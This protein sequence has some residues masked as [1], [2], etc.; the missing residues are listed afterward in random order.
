L[1]A[2]LFTTKE[3]L[4]DMLKTNVGHIVTIASMAGIVGSPGLVDYCA[5]K[6][7]AIG[8]DESLRMV[9]KI[10]FLKYYLLLINKK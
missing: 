3:V 4:P 10:L 1:T 9:K 2:H 5:S 7:G 8:F 6:A